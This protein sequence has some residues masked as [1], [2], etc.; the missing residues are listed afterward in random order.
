MAGFIVVL[1][2]QLSALCLMAAAVAHNQ[3]VPTM[4][5]ALTVPIANLA[6]AVVAGIG[7]AVALSTYAG[8]QTFIA[9]ESVVMAFAFS[10]G[11][12][13]FFGSWPAH[14]ASRLNPIE[15]LRYE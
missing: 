5:T 10:I 8:W 11:V 3:I 6:G 12:G 14:R 4:A 9:P 7:L 13:L 15:A 1:V 2:L